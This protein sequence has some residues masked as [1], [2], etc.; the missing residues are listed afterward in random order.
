MSVCLYLPNNSFMFKYFFIFLNFIF[1]QIEIHN[2]KLSF[3][4]ITE[5]ID[6]NF[7]C[8]I[9]F[10]S[11]S[12][13]IFIHKKFI[14]RQKR[15]HSIKQ[16]IFKK[17]IQMTP[18]TKNEN[19]IKLVISKISNL[20]LVLTK[21]YWKVTRQFKNAVYYIIMLLHYHVITLLVITLLC[22]EQKL[23]KEG[24]NKKII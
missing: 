23:K 9:I 20:Q 1:G 19:L 24:E 18:M 4:K 10:L 12:N 16:K 2:K 11:A 14:Q 7:K 6:R 8:K 21:D 13:F 22:E 15:L 3:Q 17:V 5:K